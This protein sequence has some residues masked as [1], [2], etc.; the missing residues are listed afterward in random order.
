MA[1]TVHPGHYSLQR[2]GNLGPGVPVPASEV[3]VYRLKKNGQK[4][5][6]LKV[7]DKDGREIPNEN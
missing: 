3:R 1:F 7:L 2:L 6:L 4:G 5:R